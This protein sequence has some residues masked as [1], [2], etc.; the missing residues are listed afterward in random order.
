[1][2]IEVLPILMRSDGDFA[3]LYGITGRPNFSVGRML[4]LCLLQELFNYADQ[5]ALDAFG[6]D[7]RWQYAWM[8]RAKR[9]IRLD[10]RLL[11]F[12]AAWWQ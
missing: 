12:S 1:M 8:S 4:G 10:G 2:Q 3:D 11:N 7:I 9:H 5:E 6:F